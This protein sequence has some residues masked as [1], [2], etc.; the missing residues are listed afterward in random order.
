MKRGRV[1]G[2]LACGVWQMALDHVEKESTHDSHW[3]GRACGAVGSGGARTE[4]V[5]VRG[6]DL[7]VQPRWDIPDKIA[8]QV[9]LAGRFSQNEGTQHPTTLDGFLRM[10]PRSSR[11]ARLAFTWTTASSMTRRAAGWTATPPVERFSSVVKPL[12]ERF[13][14]SW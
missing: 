12:R 8:L 11:P 9:A 13:G 7:R 5:P 6:R 10:P 4:G 3:H 2:W 14:R 1:V